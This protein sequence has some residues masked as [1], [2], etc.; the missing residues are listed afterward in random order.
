ME[1][2]FENSAIMRFFREISSIPRPSGKEGAIAGYLAAF[3]EERGLEWYRD[4]IGNVVIKKPGSPGAENLAPVILQGHTDMV[5]EKNAG[6]EHDFD[7]EGIKLIR[8]GDYLRADGTTLGADDGVA[9][10]YMLALPVTIHSFTRRSSVYLPYRRR[11]ALSA[12]RTRR[13][14]APPSP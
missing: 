13:L 9:V 3:A 1:L 10:A 8:E 14:R 11:S 5:C 6:T 12:R 2:D 7:L 4:D